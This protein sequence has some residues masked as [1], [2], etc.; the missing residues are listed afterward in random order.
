[1]ITIQQV[2]EKYKFDDIEFVNQYLEWCKSQGWIP[3]TGRSNCKGCK[4]MSCHHSSD[5]CCL[6]MSDHKQ[7]RPCPPWDCTCYE[8]GGRRGTKYERLF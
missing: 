3:G 8:E 6:W 4:Y 1:M 2:M 7:L 5:R